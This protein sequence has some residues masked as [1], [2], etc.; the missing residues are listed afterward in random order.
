MFGLVYKQLKC[1]NSIIVIVATYRIGTKQA[2]KKEE[3]FG[4]SKFNGYCNLLDFVCKLEWKFIISIVQN[5]QEDHFPS[6]NTMR[7]G[8]LVIKMA[9]L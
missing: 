8:L 1:L 5:R 7:F 3:R 6:K 2:Q 4:K 9:N